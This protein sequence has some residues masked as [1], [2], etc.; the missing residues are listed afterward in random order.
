MPIDWPMMAEEACQ[1]FTVLAI[2]G[3]IDPRNLSIGQAPV[4][5]QKSLTSAAGL[6]PDTFA[7]V[8]PVFHQDNKLALILEMCRKGFYE[9]HE[10]TEL[11]PLPEIL[12]RAETFLGQECTV[13]VSGDYFLL[14]E[15]GPRV[16]LAATEPFGNTPRFRGVSGVIQVEQSAVQQIT[17]VY[18][19]TDHLW[20]ITLSGWLKGTLAPDVLRVTSTTYHEVFRAFRAA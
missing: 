4:G 3:G 17:W 2:F 5:Q 16:L 18:R 13:Q 15:Q 14:R 8:Q 7:R 1:H 6:E 19:D 11:S 20:K 9:G 10:P 12:R